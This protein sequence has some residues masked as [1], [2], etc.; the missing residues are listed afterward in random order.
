MVGPPDPALAE[1]VGDAVRLGVEL[2]PGDRAFLVEIDQRDPVGVARLVGVEQR[3]H[4]GEGNRQ[5]VLRA[6]LG[7][8]C[9]LRHAG[10]PVFLCWA[11]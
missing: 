7:S 9:A 4:R 5:V 6:R 3:P 8:A 10:Y 2:A 1:E 11:R